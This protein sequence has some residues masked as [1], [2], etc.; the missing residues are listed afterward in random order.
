MVLRR[1]AAVTFALVGLAGAFIAGT[2][3]VA[4][5][6][7]GDP[8]IAGQGNTAMSETFIVNQSTGNGLTVATNGGT[9]ITGDGGSTGIHG[10]GTTGVFGDS[11]NGNGVFGRTFSNTASGVS[12]QSDGTGYG[13]SGRAAAGGTGVFGQGGENGVLATGGTFGVFASGTD[14]GVYASAPNHGVYGAATTNAGAGVEA[15]ANS[16]SGIALRVSGKAQFSRS[17]TAAITGTTTTPKSS[18]VISNVALS[19]KSLVLATAQKNVAGVWVEA[20]VPN[21]S[22]KTVTIYLNKT[23]TVSYPVAWFIV[24]KP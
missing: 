1:A 17:G 11:N 18:V 10:F 24:E 9:G 14:Y 5:A 6:A 22:A 7:T 8:V 23:V 12:G 20:A 3:A 13:V 16:A 4:T 2:G 19:G 21:V 15:Q